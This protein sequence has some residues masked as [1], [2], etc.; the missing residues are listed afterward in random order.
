MAIRVIIYAVLSIYLSRC[1]SIERGARHLKRAIEL[2]QAGE[3]GKIHMAL[4]G[5]RDI[6]K[7]SKDLNAL[8]LSKSDHM[9]GQNYSTKSFDHGGNQSGN[10]KTPSIYSFDR[11]VDGQTE[12]NNSDGSTSK[13]DERHADLSETAEPK[14]QD[15]RNLSKI[16]SWPL[17]ARRDFD[18]MAGSEI[19]FSKSLSLLICFMQ[20]IGLKKI[21]HWCGR[22][23]AHKF[24]IKLSHYRKLSICVVAGACQRS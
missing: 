7:R 8:K 15:F 9:K 18:A 24:V 21:L 19:N 12:G 20:A 4:R 2:M 5:G 17:H 6:S 23:D 3:R 10:F 14:P 1:G 16:L 22:C 13:S 11:H